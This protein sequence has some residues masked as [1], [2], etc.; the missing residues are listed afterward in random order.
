[1]AAQ[2]GGLQ[3]LPIVSRNG[4][5]WLSDEDIFY[6]HVDGGVGIYSLADGT[7]EVLPNIDVA[8]GVGVLSRLPKR[9]A[10]LFMKNTVLRAQNQR[11][12][13]IYDRSSQSTT[14]L[15]NN[16]YHPQ[17]VH[18]AHVLFIRAGD[19]WAV[20]FDLDLLK[21][22]GAEVRI[23]EGVDSQ[24]I[25]GTAAYSVSDSGRLVYLPGPEY[26]PDQSVLFWS[27]RSGN[28]EQIPLP[29]GR[30]SE[31]RVSP[32][33]ELLALTSFQADGSSDIWIYDFARETFGPRTLS[34]NAR[35]PVW[36]PDGARLVY[37]LSSVMVSSVVS[38][39]ELWIMNADGTG[40]AER[41][42]DTAAAAD[43][44]SA[45]DGKL[46]YMINEDAVGPTSLNT[47]TFSDDAWVSSPLL[48]I[49]F[50]TYGARVSPDGRWIAYGSNESGVIQIYVKPYPDLDSGK[51]QIS[52]QA[53]GSREP[54]W[55]P[56][57][58]ELFFLQLD[59]T[60]MHTKITIEGD[61]FL[62]GPVEPLITDL[63]VDTITTPNYFVSNDGERFLHFK[64][65][66]VEPNTEVGQG[67]TELVVVETFL[68]NSNDWRHLIHS[69]RLLVAQTV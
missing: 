55:G 62:P 64:A 51:W 26:F 40:Q 56:K 15:T 1:M 28:R 11:E 4:A 42:V 16:G 50:R 20:P 66:L 24:P 46:I 14:L 67:R 9:A 29:A 34:G 57:G 41:I 25:P 23:L 68:K 31:P 49:G 52:S 61:G 63:E 19:L 17:Y 59:G 58:D 6:P 37:Q 3:P 53:V 32:D 44:F 8:G 10:F 45:I 18:S 22:T 12:I 47:L 35:N 69:E 7:E 54:S 48:H 65:T 5:Y 36:T 21:V 30:Y 60:L 38:R 2:G 39:G 33:G 13:Q 43:S 27:D